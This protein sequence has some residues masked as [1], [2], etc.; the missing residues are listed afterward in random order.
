MALHHFLYLD[1]PLV[2]E[3]LSQIEGGVFDEATE[4]TTEGGTRGLAASARVGPAGVSADRSKSTHSG[5]EAVVQQTAASEFDRLRRALDADGLR[6]FDAVDIDFTDLEVSRKEIL[7]VD[8]T[9]RVSGLQR[10]LEL[11]SMMKELMPLASSFGADTSG[12]DEAAVS[13]IDALV[14]MQGANAPLPIIGT[15]PGDCGLRVALMLKRECF[16]V[17]E[18]ETEATV[19]L[20]VQRILKPGEQHT[21]GDIFGGLMGMV[22]GDQRTELLSSLQGPDAQQLGVGESQINYPGLVGTAIAIYL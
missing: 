3:F 7:E 8:A 14:K 10:I 16:L 2:R 18:L 12:V 5:T 15:V 22:S 19:L 11:G 17:Q 4:T 1:R 21:V 6:V 20:K 9:L 13:Q